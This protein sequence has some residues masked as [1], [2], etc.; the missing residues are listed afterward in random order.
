ME[1]FKL[2]MAIFMGIGFLVWCYEADKK[3]KYDLSKE[4]NK[5]KKI[6]ILILVDFFLIIFCFGAVPYFL[7]GDFFDSRTISNSSRIG[8]S[9]FIPLVIFIDTEI[10]RYGCKIE[11]RNTADSSDKPILVSVKEP[12]KNTSTPILK[13]N[14]ESIEDIISALYLCS[15]EELN[16]I[17]RM[18]GIERKKK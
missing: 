7:Y 3:K 8:I 16:M 11:T 1:E 12:P 9:L 2:L 17:R 13:I 6:G 14:S 15:D 5:D 10:W 4:T 18:L